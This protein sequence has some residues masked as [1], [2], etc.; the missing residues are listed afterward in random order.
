[1]KPLHLPKTRPPQSVRARV[2]AAIK[3][4]TALGRGTGVQQIADQTGIEA[5][6]VRHAVGNLLGQRVI[7]SAG[8]KAQARL[9]KFGPPASETRSETKPERYVPSMDAHYAG[10][11]LQP[12]PG[13]PPDR[14][15]AFNLPSRVGFRL[16]WRDGRITNLDGSPIV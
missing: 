15:Q 12:N 11:E 4:A 14:F 3:D 9:Y 13:L 2:I 1:M 10:T 7:C 16:R 5:A 8:G 6:S